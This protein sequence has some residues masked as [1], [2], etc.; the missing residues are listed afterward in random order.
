MNLDRELELWKQENLARFCK[1]CNQE[2]CSL[3]IR[4]LSEEQVRLMFSVR[5]ELVTS[6]RS[7]FFLC[8][9]GY[10]TSYTIKD[11][12]P[13]LERRRCKIYNHPLRPDICRKYPL[14][15]DPSGLVIADTDCPGIASKQGLDFLKSLVRRKVRVR[16]G[17]HELD[18]EDLEEFGQV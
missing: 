7:L 4:E 2:C 11:T 5:G 13:Q 16:D 10:R 9:D 8:A 6:S 1:K 15:T 3:N 14:Y 18:L 12:C 17:I